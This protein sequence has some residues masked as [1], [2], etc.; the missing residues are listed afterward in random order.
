VGQL[1]QNLELKKCR[2]ETSRP[3]GGTRVMTSAVY[4]S[5]FVRT[6]IFPKRKKKRKIK[7]KRTN[8]EE[9]KF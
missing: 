8:F 6:E 4:F 9:E 3:G 7:L 5:Y 2:R 1:P